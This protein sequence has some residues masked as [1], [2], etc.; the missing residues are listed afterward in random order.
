M[1]RLLSTQLFDRQSDAL[2]MI[3]E[4]IIERFTRDQHYRDLIGGV[5]Q[6]TTAMLETL[7]EC[8]ELLLNQCSED[9]PDDVLIIFDAATEVARRA[10]DEVPDAFSDVINRVLRR[11]LLSDWSDEE[12]MVGEMFRR[13][14]RLLLEQHEGAFPSIDKALIVGE[15]SE[16]AAE[17]D[18][19]T[20][21]AT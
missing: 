3:V 20:E 7:L 17:N 14:L 2:Q 12:S 4:T 13:Q 6:W 1:A 16:H 18:G 15:Q 11:E 8:T 5:K 10:P 19:V 9:N 21:A